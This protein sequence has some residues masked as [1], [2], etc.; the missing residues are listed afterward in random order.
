MLLFRLKRT[1]HL[2]IKSLWIHRLRSILTALGIIFGVCSVIAMLAIGE[3]AS[4]EAQQQIRE[5]GS[6]NIIVNS[7]R[8]P[9]ESTVTSS[10]RFALVYGLTYTDAER[11]QT[12]I[13]NVDVIVPARSVSKHIRHNSRRVDGAVVGVPQWHPD[14]AQRSL[15]RGRFF[16]TIDMRH[17]ATVCVLN[18]PIVRELFPFSDPIGQTVWAGDAVYRVVG[19]LR[20]QSQ[21]A[22]DRSGGDQ[23]TSGY[24]IYIPITTAKAWFGNVNFKRRSGSHEATVIDLHRVTV[25]VKD[26]EQVTATARAIERVLEYSHDK[27]DYEIVVPLKLLEQAKRTQRIFSIVL[28]SIAAISLIV[29]GIGIMNI[30]LATVTER[31]REIGIRRALG[32][33]RR[34]IVTQFLTETIMLAATGGLVGVGL[35]VLIPYLVTR[36][37]DMLTIVTV[38]SCGL[39]FGISVAVGLIFGLYPAYRAA[40]MDPIQALRHE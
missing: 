6:H 20:A 14:V 27:K 38:W 8:P 9:E 19:I 29:G 35:G 11:I 31:T 36:F 1:L 15:L 37:A 28:G 16:S 26:L 4:Y 39:A 18:E 7:I 22:R 17:R 32:A 40:A 10:Q 12:T 24:E 3:G 30:M 21:G 33:R 25:R 34:D 5:L 23:A 13:P 2:G